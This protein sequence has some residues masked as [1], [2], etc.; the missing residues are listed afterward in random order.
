MHHL[1]KSIPL[2][3]AVTILLLVTGIAAY[4]LWQAQRT[5][6]LTD[7][8]MMANVANESAEEST[9]NIENVII[10]TPTTQHVVSSPLTIQGK[11]TGIWY[12][13]ATLPLQIVDAN[14]QLLGA[15]YAAAQGDWMT[16]ALVPFIGHI[17]FSASNTPTGWLVVKANNPSGLPEHDDQFRMPIRFQ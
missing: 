4:L 5:D 1:R 7:P 6:K 8:G 3:V 10:T 15:G 9:Y 12:F 11:A 17:E 14:D 13:E 16:D 2:L